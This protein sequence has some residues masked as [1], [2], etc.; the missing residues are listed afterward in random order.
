MT[1]G[2]RGTLNYMAPEILQADRQKPIMPQLCDRTDVWA[3][4]VVLFVLSLGF[5]PFNGPTQLDIIK[6]MTASEE[7]I[8]ERLTAFS[9]WHGLD[10][11]L[12][13]LIMQMLRVDPAERI[14]SQ[15][16][17][18][19]PWFKQMRN[20]NLVSEHK[21]VQMRDLKAMAIYGKTPVLK[22]ITLMF[23]AVRL[24]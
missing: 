15:Q 11:N 21:I 17:L 24:D 9:C 22:K 23:M 12:R 14:S 8:Q 3:A 19:H 6:L 2:V 10:A 16:V 4:G 20:L 1:E 7:S 13:D 18:H 5:L